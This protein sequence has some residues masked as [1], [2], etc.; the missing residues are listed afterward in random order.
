LTSSIRDTSPSGRRMRG[1]SFAVVGALLIAVPAGAVTAAPLPT[2]VPF[3]D[4]QASVTYDDQDP[5]T[6]F[7]R[8]TYTVDGTGIAGETWSLTNILTEG[9]IVASPAN[10]EASCT[11]STIVAENGSNSISL[12]GAS[13]EE[14]TFSVDIALEIPLEDW[15]RLVAFKNCGENFPELVGVLLDTDCGILTFAGGVEGSVRVSASGTPSN[16]GTDQQGQYEVALRAR[17]SSAFTEDYPAS[18]TVDLTELL[19]DGVFDSAYVS[20]AGDV[21]RDGNFL[22]WSGPIAAEGT[23]TMT[24][25]FTMKSTG[26]G[27]LTLSACMPEGITYP[28]DECDDRTI[29]AMGYPAIHFDTSGIINNDILVVGEQI[30]LY[31]AFQNRSSKRMTDLGV[32]IVSVNGLSDGSA[33]GVTPVI[34]DCPTSMEPNSRGVC[35][36]TYTIVQA[37]VD[38]GSMSFSSNLHGTA[39]DQL[40]TG[41]N[42]LDTSVAPGAASSMAFFSAPWH[43]DDDIRAGEEQTFVY[44]L[45]NTGDTKLSNF[46]FSQAADMVSGGGGASAISCPTDWDGILVPN[47]TVKCSATGTGDLEDVYYGNIA[48]IAAA[49]A[50]SHTGDSLNAESP[51]TYVSLN[52]S[53]QALIGQ[54]YAEGLEGAQAGDTIRLSYSARNVGRVPLLGVNLLGS[55]EPDWFLF[56]GENPRGEQSCDLVGEL[57]V[58]ETTVCGYDYVLTQGDLDGSYF[59]IFEQMRPEGQWVSPADSVHDRSTTDPILSD[60]YS[61]FGNSVNAVLSLNTVK[62]LS[63]NAT[64]SVEELVSGEVVDLTF[65]FTNDGNTTLNEPSFASVTTS[66]TGVLS[67]PECTDV[68]TLAPGDSTNCTA[69][70]TVTDEDIV[71]DSVEFQTHATAVT[72]EGDTVLSGLTMLRLSPPYVEPEEPVTEPEAPT[73]GD[74]TEGDSTDGDP[75]EGNAAE[76]DSANADAADVPAMLAR[77]GSAAPFTAGLAIAVLLAIGISFLIRSRKA[78]ASEESALISE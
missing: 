68:A 61:M 6:G 5:A 32:D 3:T 71:E 63:G 41:N 47:E 1:L 40:I 17:G 75:T 62:S 45:Q 54:P 39:V 66:G 35:S 64:A 27:R 11:S 67:T 20:T 33:N 42:P 14:C 15:D 30:E 7:V 19:D 55:S 10:A 73:D 58:G 46:E 31:W 44:E 76:G 74:P 70:Y 43:Y 52:R 51:L 78:L 18:V 57:A 25:K 34:T 69:T 2:S 13:D 65:D 24:V 59:L 56:S 29:Y 26:D 22:T 9:L 8:A 48:T 23:A 4:P 77:T 60:S 37:D 49:T 16:L 53:G 12:S 38:R 50:T 36:S 72:V 21:T 28:G